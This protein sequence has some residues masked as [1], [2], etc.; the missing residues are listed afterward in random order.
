MTYG[1]SMATRPGG[2]GGG[3]TPTPVTG[4]TFSSST[5]TGPSGRKIP[6]PTGYSVHFFDDFTYANAT[7][8]LSRKFD[9]VTVYPYLY[10][11]QP[12][13]HS[14]SAYWARTHITFANSCL[15]IE[16]YFDTDAH[17]TRYV[18]SGFTTGGLAT[19]GKLPPY[20][21]WIWCAREEAARGVH[22]VAQV[23]GTIWPPA[24]TFNHYSKSPEP[25][26]TCSNP[27]NGYAKWPFNGES[28]VIEGGMGTQGHYTVLHWHDPALA[29]CTTGSSASQNL[30][31]HRQNFVVS[32]QAQH[33]LDRTKWYIGA[34]RCDPAVT[35]VSGPTLRFWTNENATTDVALTQ[36]ASKDLSTLAG[37]TQAYL[38]GG[39]R[40][41]YQTEASKTAAADLPT[42]KT[43]TYIDWIAYLTK[44]A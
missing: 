31:G 4:W 28:D 25:A 13:S 14:G 3:T 44:D 11:G 1:L 18:T 8:M 37:E 43:T 30:N 20:G 36:F 2:S 21:M 35:G 5:G 42:G 34:E 26:Y 22:A 27:K 19:G 17:A 15:Q 38:K 40:F 39:R 33:A 7:E 41:I 29:A 12:G 32:D 6:V 23:Y 10:D 9:G 16:G 24:G